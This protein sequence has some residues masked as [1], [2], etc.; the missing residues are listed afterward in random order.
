VQVRPG[1][2]APTS[3]P[4]GRNPTPGPS[5][6]LQVHQKGIAEA[7][8]VH[9]LVEPIWIGRVGQ[10]LRTLLIK[11]YN[12]TV[13]CAASRRHA[14]NRNEA[15]GADDGIAGRQLSLPVSTMSQW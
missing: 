2:R 15:K 5:G 6:L 1:H 9:N 4:S 3:A 12:K 8:R 13:L 11:V 10:A 14:A 7:A